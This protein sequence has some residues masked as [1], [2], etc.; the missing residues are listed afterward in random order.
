MRIVQFIT[1]M[2][3]PGGA[4]IHVKDLSLELLK[5][6]HEVILV[7][8]EGELAY[9]EC[10]EKGIQ[11]YAV[12]SLKRDIHPL[13]DFKA[14]IEIYRLFNHLQPDLIAIHSSKAGIIGRIIAKRLRIPSVFTA[15]GW[16]FTEGVPAMK[17]YLFSN[18]EKVAGKFGDAVISVSHYDAK[19]ALKHKVLSPLKLSVIQNGV[20]DCEEFNR[21]NDDT[22]HL[23]MVARFAPP[24]DH[25][26]VL[27]G[28]A[29]LRDMNWELWLIGDGPLMSN[30]QQE[31]TRLGL[32]GKVH[33]LG[34]CNNVEEWLGRSD[35]F[36]LLSNY[37][38]LPLSIIEAMRAS[39]PIV[40]SS[41]G[42]VLELVTHEENGFLIPN[43]DQ[44]T[45]IV[46][47]EKLLHSASLRTNMG[48]L[49]RQK[50]EASFT[51]ERMVK[52]TERVYETVCRINEQASVRREGVHHENYSNSYRR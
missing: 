25:L 48:E 32:E 52:E 15:H 46:A 19:L 28:L 1:R 27:Q 24:K 51:F 30:V 49:S 42:G 35:I 44:Q 2:D 7:S 4:Q 9:P 11:H 34:N 5:R 14:Y 50:Y 26:A 22:V 10:V 41:V 20:K 21:Q 43:E 31:V 47:I 36:I 29:Q 18:V 8:G 13:Q 3:E 23:T 12:S 37:E 33:F 16:A 38:G 17:R 40:A 39:L 45:F 6:G